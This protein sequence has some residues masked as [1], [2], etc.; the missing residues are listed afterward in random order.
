MANHGITQRCA[1]ILLSLGAITWTQ[2]AKALVPYVY[3]PTTEELKGSAIGIGR[4][5]AQ[6]L[7]L[8]QAKEA[9][10]LAALAVRLDPKDDRL[11]SV[12]AEAQLRSDELEGASKSLARAKTLNPDKAGLW[13][14]EAA[15]ALRAEQPDDAIP[16]IERG[17]EL[18]PDNPSAYFDLGNARIMQKD[19]PAALT[20][21]ER[22][23]KLKPE[24]W[25][26]LNNQALVLFE[27][28]E[29]TEAIRRWRRV[30]TI[31]NNPE[32]MLALSAA[33][34]Q[35]GAER[36]EAIS[37]ARTALNNNPNYVL[38]PHQIEQLWGTKI[39]Q[40]TA[41]LLAEAELAAAVERAKA[42]ATWKKRR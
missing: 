33:L 28:D 21:F 12:L 37:M 18:D 25:E 31:E 3:V 39:R 42:N 15:I 41:N 5:A 8:G 35:Q 16:L 2:P 30:L 23:T 11:W 19:L 32:P 4:T 24:F 22:A 36:D 27:M 6:L 29:R 14:A 40:A 38:V 26:A 20:S 13:F 34:H 9:A 10:Q 17:L 1:A 7:Q